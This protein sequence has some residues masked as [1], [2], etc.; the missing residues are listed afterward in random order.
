MQLSFDVNDTCPKKIIK[1]KN[2]SCS[3]LELLT[4]DAMNWFHV[5]TYEFK[6]SNHYASKNMFGVIGTITTRKKGVSHPLIHRSVQALQ[7]YSNEYN[8]NLRHTA[9]FLHPNIRRALGH[10]Y[11]SNAYR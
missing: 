9:S 2:Y 11:S 6:V 8:I 10:V 1:H 3:A 7:E 5:G 4:V